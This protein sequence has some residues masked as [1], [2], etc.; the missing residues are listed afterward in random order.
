M[1]VRMISSPAFSSVRPQLCATRLMPSVALRVKMISF[2]DE[3]LMNS[4]TLPRTVS[5]AVVVS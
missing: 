5:N 1:P 2:S 3:A 4:A